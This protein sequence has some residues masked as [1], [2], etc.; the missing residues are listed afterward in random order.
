M[1]LNDDLQ[2]LKSQMDDLKFHLRVFIGNDEVRE[3][4]TAA[5]WRLGS[6]VALVEADMFGGDTEAFIGQMY[7]VIEHMDCQ[8]IAMP[9]NQWRMVEARLR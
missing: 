5:L 7:D 4:L 1:K 2:I 9:D 8:I 6:V 3:L